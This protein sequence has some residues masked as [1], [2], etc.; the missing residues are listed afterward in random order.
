VQAKKPA[1]EKEKQRF[2]WVICKEVQVFFNLSVY[3]FKTHNL[4]NNAMKSMKLKLM[5]MSVV[6]FAT[7]SVFAQREGRGE[8]A[9]QRMDKMTEELSL[10][11]EQKT[12]IEELNKEFKEQMKPLRTDKEANAEAIAKLRKEHKTK[13]DAVL[14]ADQKKK[15]ESLHESHML[16]REA[17][18][19]EIEAYKTK[20]IDPVLKE[21]RIQLENELNDLEKKAIAEQRVKIESQKEHA[22]NVKSE[23]KQAKKNGEEV[24]HNRM[25]ELKK[26]NKTL[27]KE[28]KEVL[29]PIAKNHEKTLA[30]IKES[31]TPNQLVWE[32][33]LEALRAK[34]PELE[35]K[36]EMHSEQ[37]EK[38]M[39]KEMKKQEPK[40]EKNKASDEEEVNHKMMQFLL[41][42]PNEVIKK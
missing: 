5:M 23:L 30:N 31:L 24:D 16:K 25:I 33:D 17:M 11:P 6:I 35:Q 18:K 19:T 7:M 27:R 40:K 22:Q 32:K 42:D 9:Q 10:T 20:N 1:V 28:T 12:K 38:K 21:K 3:I 8:M 39:G 36:R 4:I 29:N 13:L 26:Q 34:Y 37:M 2:Q 41:L 15:K 14:T